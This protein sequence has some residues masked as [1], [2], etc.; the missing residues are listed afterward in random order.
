MKRIQSR[1]DMEEA[2]TEALDRETVSAEQYPFQIRVSLGSCGIA[3]GAN[4]TWEAINQFITDD[5]LRGVRTKII[6]CIGLC[7]ME[8]VVQIFESNHEPVTYGKVTPSV[9]K[10]LFQEHIEKHLIVQEYVVENI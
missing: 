10:R 2:R 7:A 6:G 8:P 4:E 1:S 9:V 3:A 5:D